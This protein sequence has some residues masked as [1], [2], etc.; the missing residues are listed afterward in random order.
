MKKKLTKDQRD[1]LALKL[2]DKSIPAETRRGMYQEIMSQMLNPKDNFD[3]AT[4]D[5]MEG[6]EDYDIK[7]RVRKAPPPRLP[8]MGML[9]KELFEGQMIGMFESKQDLYL[10]MAHYINNLLDRI[11]ELEQQVKGTKKT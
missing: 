6:V 7:K 1:I 2:G 9:P 8:T 10:I 5:P 4:F 11:E 3:P